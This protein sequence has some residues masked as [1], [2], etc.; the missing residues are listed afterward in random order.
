M[1][2]DVELADLRDFLAEHPPFA[3][4]PKTVQEALPARASVVYRRRDSVVLPAGEVPTELL[5]VRSGAVEVRD[6]AGH[7][8][9]RGAAGTCLGGTALRNGAPQPTTAMAI[10]D[11]LLLAVPADVFAT[12]CADHPDLAAF[13]AAPLGGRLRS[14]VARQREDHEP[15]AGPVLRSRIGDLVRRPPV[16]VPLEATVRAAAQRMTEE[17]ISSVL[18]TDGDR[19]AGILTDRDLRGR[20]VA[21][22]VDTGVSVAEVMTPDPITADPDALALEAMLELVRRNIHH[23]P[24]LRQGRVVGMVT[25]TDL[26]RLEQANPVHLVGDVAKATDAAA[27]AEVAGRLAPLVESLVR[28]GSTAHDA[29]RVVT[30]VGDA[31]ERRLIELAEAE[32]GPPPVPYAWVTLGSRARFEQALGPDQDHALVLHD[33]AT[34]AHDAWFAELADRVTLGLE[35]AGYPRCRGQKMASNPRWRMTLAGWERQV[36]RWLSAPTPDAVLECSVFFDLRHLAG[37]A[38]LSEA[39]VEHQRTSVRGSPL[40]LAYLAGAAARTHP[41]VGFFRG[42]VVERSGDHRDSLDVKRGGLLIVSEVARVHAL[43]AGSARTNTLDRLEDAESDGRLSSALAADLRDA[44]EFLGHLRL[45]HQADLVRE[46]R[47]PD[48]WI[49]TDALSSF[50]K[51]HLKAAFGVIRSAQSALAMRYPVRAIT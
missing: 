4:L 8:V 12:L 35:R 13:F 49:A 46:G 26:L 18:V 37:D 36:M 15:P 45:R 22:G 17:R 14:A 3:W 43:A 48:N 47:V 39:L 50:E 7:L 31:V 51:Q 11:S 21:A 19:L 23:L 30:T 27:V 1:A 28:Q 29:G 38:S 16:A 32:L 41:P 10:E 25:A 42:L 6:A 9:E 33:D 44:W 20:V 5:V 2:L 34:E 40:F 24:L